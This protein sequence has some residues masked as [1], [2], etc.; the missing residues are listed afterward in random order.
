MKKYLNIEE[1][2]TFLNRAFQILDK[3]KIPDEKRDEVEQLIDRYES[4]EVIYYSVIEKDDDYKLLYNLFLDAIEVSI[5]LVNF[6]QLLNKVF[7]EDSFTPKDFLNYAYI[8]PLF[9]HMKDKQSFYEQMMA[10]SQDV[11]LK[12][13]VH[14]G[15]EG[16]IDEKERC[17]DESYSEIDFYDV[18]QS[19]DR[20]D[21]ILILQ[22]VQASRDMK[23]R[24]KTALEDKDES[25]FFKICRDPNVDFQESYYN[26]L[27]WYHICGIQRTYSSY[28]E[29]QTL[30]TTRDLLND[31]YS[32]H[33]PLCIN[34]I[35]LSLSKGKVS[36]E[37]NMEEMY[38]FL[39]QGDKVMV[40]VIKEGKQFFTNA[41]AVMKLEDY[42][43]SSP[44]YSK[45]Y[46]LESFEKIEK[47]F[48]G[49]I[50][51]FEDFKNMF[52]IPKQAP[53]SADE[54]KIM[55]FDQLPPMNQ[56]NEDKD[57]HYS[58]DKELDKDLCLYI[59]NVLVENELL[60]Y[61]PEIAESFMFRFSKECNTE[62]EPIKLVWKGSIHE[63]YQFVYCVADNS[64]K[65]TKKTY[66]FFSLSNGEE[67][68]TTSA[69]KYAERAMSDRMIK[70]FQS[71]KKMG[72]SLG[73]IERIQEKHIAKDKRLE[74]LFKKD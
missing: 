31:P 52:L 59:Y 63:L 70:V 4:E 54:P 11:S 64:S 22:S 71:L 41:D 56:R 50:K 15:S 18:L 6:P 2:V 65:I 24:L 28:S 27:I 32:R 44:Y 3:A 72:I 35:Y 30:E 46:E 16:R 73:P 62:I 23:D 69:V 19:L 29:G 10:V 53:Q 1:F 5:Y 39:L 47:C 45:L 17:V 33:Q 51:P 8:A 68:K 55:T 57:A 13:I 49:A 9:L 14:N 43:Q 61:T 48:G 38:N 37:V 67:I 40:D 7:N 26:A 34:D 36:S 12:R 42:I 21:S 20:K 58:L 74:T 25:V 60:G 66:D